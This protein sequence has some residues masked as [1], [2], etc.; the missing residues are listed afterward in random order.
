MDLPLDQ[1]FKN[2][3]GKK[4]PALAPCWMKNIDFLLYQAPPVNPND[5]AAREEWIE[6]ATFMESDLQSLLRM[7]HEAFWCQVVF[8]ESL[9]RCIDSYL[10]FAPRPFDVVYT[11]PDNVQ[12]K[13]DSLHRLIFMTCLRM[14][15]HKESK[16]DFITP[17]IFGDIL[18]ENF[19]FD[20]PKLMDLCVLYGQDNKPLLTKMLTN[21]F[22]Q[23]PKYSDDLRESLPTILH[24]L[25]SVCQKCGLE[26]DSAPSS[27]QKL[28][29]SGPTSLTT[30]PISEF[31]DLVF[32]VSD[33]AQTLF[34]FL[35]VYD[36][37]AKHMIQDDFPV[38]WCQR[39]EAILSTLMSAIAD[40]DWT[41]STLK[42]L[43]K[44]KLNAALAATAH[45]FHSLVFQNTLLPLME[46][47]SNPAE[48]YELYLHL[49]TA[50]LGE[51][52]MLAVH[53]V[54]FPF[55]EDRDLLVQCCPGI[56][57]TQLQFIEDGI[58]TACCHRAMK[59]EGKKGKK[60]RE[61]SFAV[62]EAV[63]PPPMEPQETI[64]ACA[65]KMKGI[66]LDSLISSVHDLLPDLGEGFIELCLEELDYNVERVINC[67]LEGR[68]PPSLDDIE[69]TL[70]RTKPTSDETESL[71]EQRRNIF[72]NDDFDVFSKEKVAS[73][74]IHQGKKE[75]S[76]DMSVLEDK[77]GIENFRELYNRY[78]S[79]DVES[80]YDK[81]IEYDDEYDDTYDSHLI[82]A[83][84]GDS[85]DE[86]AAKKVPLIFGNLNQRQQQASGEESED[87]SDG[88]ESQ[89]LRDAF[90]Q[91][92]AKL[93]EAQARRR[94]TQQARRGRPVNT[95][96]KKDVV[97]AAKGQGQSS[98]VLRNR[99]SK[100]K[101][102][103]KN[104]KAQADRKRR[105]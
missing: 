60:K 99:A 89:P 91:D 18:Y 79:E 71:L 75:K 31:Q 46:H 6:R 78:G 72:D 44:G 66:E 50:V 40:R 13:Q 16:K 36:A 24:V 17:R 104:R 65:P 28:Q 27:P 2:R 88:E 76:Q 9:H 96:K 55:S 49:M 85:A 70:E 48:L 4:T 68:L 84:D 21:I 52:R 63:A 102:K 83:N 37:A 87:D 30:M 100:E 42:P 59:S 19:L 98:D 33:T 11:L 95:E 34:N 58:Q 47:A 8:D 23:Q 69:R 26:C 64:G 90:V 32:Y 3:G 53:E 51:I 45:V 35:D 105:V 15:T 43:L 7:P 77:S 14:A 81:V 41:G 62:A 56:D 74:Q 20:V 80:I 38:K 92:P 86:L 1:R 22:T 29:T 101:N 73:D 54:L 103:N 39:S 93:R 97:G 12:V 94:A 10:R 82:G 5:G 67:V 57:E 25:N 61:V